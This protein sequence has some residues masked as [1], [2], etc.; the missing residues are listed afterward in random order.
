M[1][2]RKASNPEIGARES[3]SSIEAA[4][5]LGLAVGTVQRLF[6]SG[7]LKGWKTRGG[8]RKIFTHS[9]D[10]YRGTRGARVGSDP[11]SDSTAVRN[12][13]GVRLRLLLIEDS[14]YYVK[15]ITRLVTDRFP[16]LD[17]RVATDGIS[18]L[19]LFGEIQ[20]DFLIV[21]I[22]LPDIDGAALLSSL[23]SN[24]RFSKTKVVVVT[25]LNSDELEKYRYALESVPVVFKSNLV[26]DLPP[27]LSSAVE[28]ASN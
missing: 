26:K 20:P 27:I 1:N 15:I 8:H 11:D 13:P 14:S 21:D 23:L 17:L 10:A 2:K 4:R 9:V 7:D 22:M 18:G 28:A 24:P 3:M 12:Q 6:D 25:G 19:A 16:D 5:I